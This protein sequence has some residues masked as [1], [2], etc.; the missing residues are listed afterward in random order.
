MAS[1]RK[2]LTQ[3]FAT[4][5]LKLILQVVGL[6]VLARLLGPEEIGIYTIAAVFV[7][8]AQELRNFA[9]GHYIIQEPD[10]TPHRFRAAF[11]V[12]LI[13]GFSMGLALY[14]AAP[15]AGT[16]YGEPGIESILSLVALN[17]LLVP[18]GTIVLAYFRREMQFGKIMLVETASTMVHT[19]TGII[20]AYIGFSYMS[21]AWA[22]IAGTVT[23]LLLAQLMRPA[24]IPWLP[25]VREIK[26]VFSF[27][28]YMTGSTMVGRLGI[29]IPSLIIGKTLGMPAV[30]LLSRGSSL[31][32]IFD[33]LIVQGARP[34][35]MPYLSAKKRSGGE[36]DTSYLYA[37]TCVSGMAWPFF[38]SLA[39]LADPVVNLVLGPKWTEIIPLLSVW[40]LAPSLRM[41]TPFAQDLF[42][43]SGS[44]KLFFRLQT[45]MISV[46]VVVVTLAA[47]HSLQALI[48]A[49]SISQ[50]I[51]QAIVSPAIYRLIKTDLRAHWKAVVPSV[52]VALTTA[53]A[54]SVS[55]FLTDSPDTR[56]LTELSAASFAALLGWITGCYMVKHPLLTEFK[57]IVSAIWHH[58]R[59]L[60]NSRQSAK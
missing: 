14:L 27:G 9:V 52:Y 3:T 22:A 55:I 24:G 12:T 8:F 56:P 32:R 25:G 26:R 34:V 54:V 50:F 51:Q 58:S 30:G 10:L 4:T 7:G 33:R 11:S 49:F 29:D 38:I 46:H 18:F 47:F 2:S 40:V 23:T 39:L 45:Y 41:L 20:L 37:V 42:V 19:A 16:L 57:R 15:F 44:V 48:I 31:V 36:L 21:L 6:I 1:I 53:I 43:A 60:M 35:I 13:L 17:F 59:R 28:L 5:Y